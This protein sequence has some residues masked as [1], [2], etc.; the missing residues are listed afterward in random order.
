M[1]YRIRFSAELMIKIQLT[2]GYTAIVDDCDAWVLGPAWQVRRDDH[3]R[4]A[5][6]TIRKDGRN[7]T[8]LLHRELLAA[9]LKGNEHLGVDH[10]DG[11]GLN[12]RRGNLR[13]ATQPQNNANQRKARGTSSIFKGVSK[14]RGRWQAT[15][16]V[17]YHQ[18]WLGAFDSEIEAA[19]AYDDAAVLAFG[20]FAS[21]N[22]A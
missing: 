21:I 22:N 19:R 7:V 9:D 15:I 18:R 17:N 12:N 20:E 8:L 16:K 14:Y 2:Q 5:C 10:R 4:Y 6:R 1:I 13:L 3:R 11:D